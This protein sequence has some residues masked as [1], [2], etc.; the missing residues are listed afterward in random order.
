MAHGD[1]SIRK[2]DNGVYRVQ[3]SFG[4]DPITGKYPKVCRTVRGTLADARRERDRLRRDHENGLRF[5]AAKTT[6]SEWA[7][8]WVNARE[9]SGEY[10]RDKIAYDRASVRLLSGYIGGVKLSEVTPPVIEAVYRRIMED[11]TRERGSYST[12]TLRKVHVNLNQIMKKAVAFD[13]IIRNPCDRVEAPKASK[14]TRNAL[15]SD[16]LARFGRE[17]D[18]E[19]AEAFEKLEAR[20]CKRL[21]NGLYQAGRLEGLSRAACVVAV[22]LGMSSGMR[23]S[24]I[25]GLTWG[26]VELYSGLVHVVHSLSPDMV[27][28]D[29]KTDAGKR[30]LYLDER[31]LSELSAWKEDQEK[32]LSALSVRQSGETPVICSCTGG[33]LGKPA[34]ERWWVPFRKSIGFPDLKFHELR[35]THATQLLSN[36][37]DV[38]TVQTRLG[39]ATSS[40][41]L[42]FYAHAVP[43]N[44]RKAAGVIAGILREGREQ[45]DGPQD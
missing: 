17:V 10:S 35:H 3:V 32:A 34:F 30:S 43:E 12:G 19:A 20:K 4:R 26:D 8:A 18:R 25:L 1:G 9:A 24:E 2:I 14:T 44:D 38:K 39:H 28:K 29:P 36:G 21:S 23:L 37:I 11:K 33:F 42:D 6:F 31:T 16:D 45:G 13:L 40:V 15:S 27:L 41:T 7:S 5:D 22:K